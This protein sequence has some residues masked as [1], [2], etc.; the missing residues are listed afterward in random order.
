MV[1][2]STCSE[3]Q[4][5][6]ARVESTLFVDESRVYLVNHQDGRLFVSIFVLGRRKGYLSAIADNLA[7]DNKLRLVSKQILDNGHVVVHL[8][9]MQENYLGTTCLP[10]HKHCLQ[11]SWNHPTLSVARRERDD[12][13][14]DLILS[15]FVHM[16]SGRRG[17]A[18][19]VIVWLK[20]GLLELLSRA[21]YKIKNVF[22]ELVVYHRV[23]EAHFLQ[24]AVYALRVMVLCRSRD[25][26]VILQFFD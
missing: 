10:C 22:H 20:V 2:A 16:V 19:L 5:V 21:L 12:Q 11:K 4:N 8:F 13:L 1:G 26:G 23:T 9:L 15:A 18:S 25:L 24:K 7:I 6:P 14:R 17:E 3:A